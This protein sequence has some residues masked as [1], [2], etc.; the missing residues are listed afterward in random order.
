[1]GMGRVAAVSAPYMELSTSMSDL[2]PLGSRPATADTLQP[3]TVWRD[4]QTKKNLNA[5]D[6]SQCEFLTG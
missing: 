5:H 1:M 4:R 2:T 6:L 3:L